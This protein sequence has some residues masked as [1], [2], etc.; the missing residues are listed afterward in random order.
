MVFTL[1]D[2][3]LGLLCPL[4]DPVFAPL[5]MVTALLE[6]VAALL[7]PVLGWWFSKKYFNFFDGALFLNFS[8]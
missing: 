8:P 4:V 6:P 7:G 5:D 1:L 3:A 2:T